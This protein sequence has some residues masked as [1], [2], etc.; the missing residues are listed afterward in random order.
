VATRLRHSLAPCPWVSSHAPN[1]PENFKALLT[2]TLRGI[3]CL[4]IFNMRSNGEIYR[5]E[6]SARLA[7]RLSKSQS[8]TNSIM[9]VWHAPNDF[10]PFHNCFLFHTLFQFS[11]LLL[12][13]A[14]LIRPRINAVALEGIDTGLDRL[15]GAALTLFKSYKYI[16]IYIL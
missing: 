14:L 13:K 4:H 3:Y 15:S 5:P 9:S 6:G 8:P 16:L 1:E 12:R 2:G 11:S 7:K 10:V